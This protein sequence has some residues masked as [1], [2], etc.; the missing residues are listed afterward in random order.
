MSHLQPSVSQNH[1]SFI[2]KRQQNKNKD[3]ALH[4]SHTNKTFAQKQLKIISIS[5]YLAIGAHTHSLLPNT[6][7]D[8]NITYLLNTIPTLN[9]VNTKFTQRVSLFQCEI[10]TP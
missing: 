4:N 2:T 3:T 7:R 1:P 8:T 9:M 6:H 10:F 5:M